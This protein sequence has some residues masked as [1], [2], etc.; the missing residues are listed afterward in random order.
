M[1]IVHN[2]AY[3]YYVRCK[4]DFCV[5]YP[6]KITCPLKFYISAA[7]VDFM[8]D[9]SHLYE[10]KTITLLPH[11][12]L[13]FV[14]Y[15]TNVILSDHV[16]HLI[17][18]KVGIYYICCRNQPCYVCIYIVLLHTSQWHAILNLII[19]FVNVHYWIHWDEHFT[20][21]NISALFLAWDTC[22]ESCKSIHNLKYYRYI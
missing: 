9:L 20:I 21:K 4:D 19:W 5:Q 13:H 17:A 6:S 3:F 18:Y 14:I 10:T 8:I 2:I 16:P 15:C 7:N 11:S 1:Y 22:I 12:T